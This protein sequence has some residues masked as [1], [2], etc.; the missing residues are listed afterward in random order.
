MIDKI[1][2]VQDAH[3]EKILTHLHRESVGVVFT[4]T[5]PT[6]STIPIGKLVIFDDTTTIKVYL[7]TQAGN[8]LMWTFDVPGDPTGDP[9]AFEPGKLVT[10]KIIDVDEDT[11]IQVEESSDEDIIRMDAGGTEI[12]SADVDQFAV[13]SGIKLGLEGNAGDTY[14]TYNSGTSYLE[15]YVDG[16][17]RMEM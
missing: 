16:T 7:K 9:D 8:V 10:D 11:Q 14:M 3:L 1:D 5:E 2:S 12:V 13:N 4:S 6:D 17:K 15:I